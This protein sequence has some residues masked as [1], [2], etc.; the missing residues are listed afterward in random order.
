MKVSY[1]IT[2]DRIYIT[3][4]DVQISPHFYSGEFM[5]P[6]CKVAIVDLD[7]VARLEELRQRVG[8]PI[9]ITSGYRCPKHNAEVGGSPVSLHMVGAAADIVVPGMD[10]IVVANYASTIGFGGIIVYRS[11]VHVDL[12]LVPY[13]QWGKGGGADEV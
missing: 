11:H 5:C 6:C 2:K 13:F 3:D 7:L 4:Q 9:R 12:R 8:E 10:P 1:N